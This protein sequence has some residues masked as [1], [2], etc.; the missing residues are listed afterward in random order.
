MTQ[1]ASG[2][3][4]GNGKYIET[5]RGH[6]TSIADWSVPGWLPGADEISQEK[7]KKGTQKW[8]N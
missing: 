4:R 5:S 1:K 2:G 3:Q 8:K 7:S 6:E